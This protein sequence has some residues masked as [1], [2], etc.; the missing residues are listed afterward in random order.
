MV[1]VTLDHRPARISQAPVQSLLL[2]YG[3]ECDQRRDQKARV[4][5]SGRGDDLPR[6]IP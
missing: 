4:H 1:L 2:H 6:W 5:E 3:D